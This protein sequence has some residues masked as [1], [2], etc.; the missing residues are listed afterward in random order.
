M[1]S[2]VVI[3]GPQTKGQSTRDIQGDENLAL[4]LI[5]IIIYIFLKY[6]HL[7]QHLH[8]G[9]TTH[10][11]FARTVPK[12]KLTGKAGL[13]QTAPNLQRETWGVKRGR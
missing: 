6:Q 10:C 7:I 12:I 5:I 13:L 3:G 11:W 4:A 8:L 1:R 9:S 2:P